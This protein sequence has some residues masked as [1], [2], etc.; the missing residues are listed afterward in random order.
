MISARKVLWTVALAATAAGIFA[1]PAARAGNIVE[2][3]TSVKAPP[4]PELKPVTVDPK[5]TALL[6]VDFVPQACNMQRRPRCVDSVQPVKKLL[7]EARGKGMMV[8]FTAY[9]TLSQKDVLPEIAPTASEPFIIAFLDKYLKTDLEKMLKDKGIQTVI[10][11]GTAAHGAVVSTASASA[12][13]GFK[14]ILPVDGISS[15][16]TY[17][18]Q[19][20]VWHL[21]NAAVIAGKT[22]PTKIDMVKF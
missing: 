7:I 16:N 14:V 2:E 15:E 11:V 19:Y 12:E 13:R 20:T 1:A 5:T 21:L 9:G 6:M 17:A 18:E 4:A 10:I 8:V 22:T 3:W